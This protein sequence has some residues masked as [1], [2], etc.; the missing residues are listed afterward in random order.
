MTNVVEFIRTPVQKKKPKPN[1]DIWSLFN[2][3]TKSKHKNDDKQM[4]CDDKDR[5]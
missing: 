4:K 2:E 3:I 1:R 5:L